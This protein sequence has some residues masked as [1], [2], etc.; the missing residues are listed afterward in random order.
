MPQST[1]GCPGGLRVVLLL[2]V[3]ANVDVG[4]PSTK[5]A[6]SSESGHAASVARLL[7]EPNSTNH[8]GYN[9]TNGCF[10][11]YVGATWDS[12]QSELL[13]KQAALESSKEDE[14][15]VVK[16]TARGV[17][18][19]SA[20]IVLLL[21]GERF[22]KPVLFFLGFAAAGTSSLAG[23][24]VVVHIYKQLDPCPDCCTYMLVGTMVGAVMGGAAVLWLVKLCYVILGGTAGG[25]LG[26]GACE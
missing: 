13:A 3:F 25:A 11:E 15:Q 9:T 19:L 16:G 8:T 6:L 4:A 18:Y 10:V 7:A 24:S 2:V 23:L 20:G 1:Q 12:K 21:F 5:E 17:C 26:Y 14:Y 22:F